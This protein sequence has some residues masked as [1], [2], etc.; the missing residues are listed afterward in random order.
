[1]DE[2]DLRYSTA[3]QTIANYIQQ[4]YSRENHKI[5]EPIYQ[6]HISKDILSKFDFVNYLEIISLEGAV[7]GAIKPNM[8]QYIELLADNMTI[9]VVPYED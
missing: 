3:S 1:M 6:S 9:K 7:N 2:D 5:G 8:T 4:K